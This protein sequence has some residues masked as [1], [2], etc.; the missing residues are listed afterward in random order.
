M[1]YID[2]D[3][4]LS[5]FHR[6]YVKHHLLYRIASYRPISVTSYLSAHA[7]YQSRAVY[8]AVLVHWIYKVFK[9]MKYGL[10][11]QDLPSLV[12]TV[13]DGLHITSSQRASNTWASFQRYNKILVEGRKLCDAVERPNGI[14]Q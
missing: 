7:S 14:S 12:K 9:L 4:Y 8:S 10:Y 5:A 2:E 13:F 3:G 1:R 11:V 6:T